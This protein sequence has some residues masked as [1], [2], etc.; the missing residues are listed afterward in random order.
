MTSKPDN[1]TELLRQIKDEVVDLHESPLY[2]ERIRNKVYP[3]VGE[4]NH[5][6]QIMFVGEAPGKNEAETGRPF[7]GAAGRVLSELLQTVGISREEVYI[8]NIVKDR[9]PNNRDPLPE[10]IALYAPFLDRQIEIIRPKVI[11]TLGRHSMKYIMEKFGLAGELQ[12]ISRI[13]GQVY[14]TKTSYG[15][16]EIVPMYHPATL[17]YN[18][19]TKIELQKDFQ[20]LKDLLLPN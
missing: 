4:G 9:P 1:R 6:A 18:S 13:H 16:I 11:A 5:Y 12:T 8:T 3:V 7:C 15:T 17:L 10:E 2:K 19:V 14:E 20:K